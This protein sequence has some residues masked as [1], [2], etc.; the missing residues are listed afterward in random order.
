M[1]PKHENP[2]LSNDHRAL[3]DTEHHDWT[4]NPIPFWRGMRNINETEEFMKKGGT[5]LA[6]MSTSE[7]LKVAV[8]Y[9][10]REQA[11]KCLLFKIVP[12]N[13]MGSPANV[14]WLSVYPST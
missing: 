14:E 8:K 3:N 11:K 7:D 12:P 9:S 5:E 2:E 13:F 6:F 1:Q 4:S 10:L